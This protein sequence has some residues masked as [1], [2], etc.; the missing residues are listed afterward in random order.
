MKRAR[1]ELTSPNLPQPTPDK[2]RRP[3]IMTSRAVNPC[4][5]ELKGELLFETSTG[6]ILKCGD[7]I[8]KWF[9]KEVPIKE[10]VTATRAAC[11]QKGK[12]GCIAAS[13]LRRGIHKGG[14]VLYYSMP[15]AD[16][17]LLDWV[18]MHTS[19][20]DD[21]WGD[22]FPVLWSMFLDIAQHL[23][24]IHT[25]GVR[26]IHGDIK[27]E[28]IV[29]TG[30]TRADNTQS[31][32]LHV[33]DFDDSVPYNSKPLKLHTPV[34]TDGYMA[35]EMR[36]GNLCGTFTDA[37]SLGMVLLVLITRSVRFVG[38]PDLLQHDIRRAKQ[39][40]RHQSRKAPCK[41]AGKAPCKAPCNHVDP[42]TVEKALD[43][44]LA[45]DYLSR[46]SIPEVL[47]L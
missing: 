10:V 38:N 11:S 29:M 35:P 3:S 7:T 33:I 47:L 8:V 26:V 41:A 16:R 1:C 21:R 4:S 39:L 19:F 45:N 30:H 44:L 34:G 14:T 28:N 15:A 5:K 18:E 13:S 25:T 24:T 9:S 17:D 2:I 32:D 23:V 37:W 27:P 42:A 6:G 40:L 20:S 31:I 43:G 22:T 36:R 46:M 12:P